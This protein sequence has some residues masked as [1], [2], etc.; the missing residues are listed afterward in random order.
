VGGFVGE[1]EKDRGMVKA[2][3][4]RFDGRG[5]DRRGKLME[6]ARRVIVMFLD[7]FCFV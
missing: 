4:G 5:K 6:R 7:R 2:E 3:V 1:G